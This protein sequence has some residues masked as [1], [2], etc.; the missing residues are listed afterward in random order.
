MPTVH[1]LGKI[2]PATAYK[3]NVSELPQMHYK[4]TDSDLGVDLIVR[5]VE[6]SIDVECI[7]NRFSLDVLGEFHKIA[8][9]LARAS[10][11]LLSFATG[12]NFVV[13]FDEFV[14]P[15]GDRSPF[16]IQDLQRNELCTILPMVSLGEKVLLGDVASFVFSEPA[17]FLALDDLITAASLHHLTVVNAARSIEG[18]RHLMA[19]EGMSRSEAWELFR[20]NLNLNEKYLRLITDTSKSGRHGDGAFIP[21]TITTEIISR[22]WVI[23]N[24]FLEFRKRGNVRLPLDKF[25]VLPA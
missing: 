3:L 15:N 9:D 10:V 23:M 5:I 18:L 14:D 6:S 4:S 21:G 2:V 24:R 17:L 11:N 13:V 8:N 22:S 16:V 7:A 19:L 20:S 12:I 25:P 1:F